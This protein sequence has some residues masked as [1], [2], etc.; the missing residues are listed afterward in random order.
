MDLYHFFIDSIK[1]TIFNK[2]KTNNLFLNTILSTISL[3]LFT[4]ITKYFYDNNNKSI[5][6]YDI[7]N[8]NYIKS[9][10]FRKNSMI[11]EGKKSVI[12]CSYNLS[13]HVSSLYTERFK[14]VWN[15]IIVNMKDNPSIYQIK[16]QV[17]NNITNTSNKYLS[18]IFFVSQKK[19][20][21][22]DKEKKIYIISKFDYDEDGNSKDNTGNRNSTI[23]T[24]KIIIEIFSYHIDTHQLTE[25]IEDIT[26]KYLCSIQNE[27]KYKK[28][29]YTLIKS[30]YE[31]SRL[32][33]WNEFCFDTSRSFQN[34]FFPNKDMILNKINF[35]SENKKWYYDKGIPYTLGIGLYGPPGTGKTS[36]IKALAKKLDLHIIILS[37]KIIKTRKQL[38]EFYF[39][40]TYNSD[41]MKNSITFDKKLIVFE[42]VDCIGDIVLDRSKKETNNSNNDKHISNELNITNNLLNQII[43]NQNK[44]LGEKKEIITVMKNNN[45][46]DPITLDDILNLWDGIR[47]TPG[48]VLVISSNHYNKLD[49]A[50]IRPGRIDLD[51]CL[52][53][54][55]H[56][57]ISQMYQHLFEKPIN[58]L[59]LNSI[60]EKCLTPADIVNT[61]ISSISE[62]IEKEKQEDIFIQLLL[63]KC[64][65]NNK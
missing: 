1:M 54:V 41:N 22:L 20:F 45:S 13:S 36:F 47:E 19:E 12:T 33:C 18:D 46:E 8:M 25:F 9:F 37:F 55:N 53:Y 7:F 3:S 43:D 34:L 11:L 64:N 10:F 50:L 30:N 35:F 52:D 31:D 15:Y 40:Q 48:R 63:D 4:Y 17:Y 16:E 59:K 58:T 32:E 21:I 24:D 23:K 49:P 57:T 6:I 14:A 62:N 44:E 56:D 42:D 38:N 26:I 39:E 27:R 51:I 28:F 29:I 60:K 5:N 61:F 65:K 2:I